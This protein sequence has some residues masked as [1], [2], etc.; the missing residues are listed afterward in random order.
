MTRSVRVLLYAFIALAVVAGAQ[1]FR[2]NTM[3][4]EARCNN[5]PNHSCTLANDNVNSAGGGVTDD[6]RHCNFQ[7]NH[8]C[9][10]N[11]NNPVGGDGQVSRAG[12]GN[13]NDNHRNDNLDN[14]SE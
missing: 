4:A 8:P 1:L 13:T 5:Q 11:D 3:V 9:S 6:G 12:G 7:P 10:I 2:S 14:N